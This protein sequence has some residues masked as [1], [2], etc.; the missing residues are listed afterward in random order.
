MNN[1]KIIDRQP[2]TLQLNYK[3]RLTYKSKTGGFISLMFYLA[4]AVVIGL[5]FYYFITQ[6]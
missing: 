3:S 1:L 6:D 5:N 4:C 2:Y